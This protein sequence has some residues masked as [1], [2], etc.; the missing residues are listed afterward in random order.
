MNIPLPLVPHMTLEYTHSSEL[1][2]A[3]ALWFE[4]GV[5]PGVSEN[6]LGDYTLVSFQIT[7][8]HEIS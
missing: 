3:H 1:A 5:M 8:H 6:K 2:S 4:V 7:K